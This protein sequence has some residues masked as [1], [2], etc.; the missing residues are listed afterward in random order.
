MMRDEYSEKE[1]IMNIFIGMR[2]YNYILTYRWN[3][4][5]FFTSDCIT[6]VRS[7]FSS[8]AIASICLCIII[9]VCVDASGT[10]GKK[11]CGEKGYKEK[12]K[13]IR[14]WALLFFLNKHFLDCGMLF[15][16]TITFLTSIGRGPGPPIERCLATPPKLLDFT[17]A[18]PPA[19]DFLDPLLPVRKI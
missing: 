19:P 12:K 13:R 18:P 5:S 16:T 1:I 14:W 8:E 3:S 10:W 11:F 6:L 15:Q 9:I 17:F 7:C 4:R 2:T